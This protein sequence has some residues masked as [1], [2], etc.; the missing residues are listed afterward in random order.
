MQDDT[1]TDAEATST[2]DSTAQGPVFRF[3]TEDGRFVELPHDPDAFF[4]V[5]VDRIQIG[6][7]C[8]SP[9]EAERAID[10]L[11][12]DGHH[13]SLVTVEAYRHVEGSDA[14]VATIPYHQRGCW[15]DR[16]QQD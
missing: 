2:A 4:C 9:S 3:V 12:A 5:C 11:L 8:G 15:S 16:I 10:A 6:E 7:A 14:P 13:V 1:R